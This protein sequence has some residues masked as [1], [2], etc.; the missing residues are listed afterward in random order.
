MAR[1]A[2]IWFSWVRLRFPSRDWVSLALFLHDVRFVEG[3]GPDGIGF[4]IEIHTDNPK[5]CLPEIK[6]ILGK[7]ELI[8]GKEGCMSWLFDKRGVIVLPRL[9]QDAEILALEV[10]ADEVTVDPADET[11]L[12]FLCSADDFSS[13]KGE[14]SKREISVTHSSVDYIPKSFV[15]VDPATL[16]NIQ[17]IIEL[18]EERPDVTRVTLNIDPARMNGEAE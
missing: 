8:A 16:G 7:A 9:E 5:R 18:L 13:V 2:A 4:I 10:G 14:L 11:A 1:K 17:K 15:D 12:Q 3:T 6:K